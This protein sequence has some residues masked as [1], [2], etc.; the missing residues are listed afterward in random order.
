MK[1]TQAISKLIFH[2][3]DEMEIKFTKPQGKGNVVYF[4]DGEPPVPIM[5][6]ETYDDPLHG[7]ERFIQIQSDFFNDVDVV[8]G[9]WDSYD[10]IIK[11][12]LN[13]LNEPGPMKAQITSDIMVEQK[14]SKTYIVTESQKKK[15]VQFLSKER[16]VES[17][18]AT[19]V[20][21]RVN[22]KTLESFIT[23]AVNQYSNP[24]EEFDKDYDYVD[25]VIDLASDEFLS[26]FPFDYHEELDNDDVRFFLTGE[27]QNNF[28]EEL[29]LLYKE[30]CKDFGKS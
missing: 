21:R 3:L 25:T 6:V 15:L 7:T 12:V 13:K 2:L 18:F 24:C 9:F 23:Y 5:K 8:F 27:F 14:K 22:K 28:G 17:H 19:W 30:T 16:L 29:T 11:W 4:Y 26:N 1:N 10:S 20:R